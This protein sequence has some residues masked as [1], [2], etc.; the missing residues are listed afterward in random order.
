MRTS[1]APSQ[2]IAAR[3]P[4]RLWLGSVY[5]LVAQNLLQCKLP[6]SP[7]FRA[8][9]HLIQSHGAIW[10]YMHITRTVYIL[11]MSRLHS[12]MEKGNLGSGCWK[13]AKDRT[14]YIT[15]NHFCKMNIAE[16]LFQGDKQ[17]LWQN[18]NL[19]GQ[20]SENREWN[21]FSVMFFSINHVTMCFDLR[22]TGPF[23]NHHRNTCS[24]KTS[25]APSR[26]KDFP[27][28]ETWYYN[29]TEVIKDE[30]RKGFMKL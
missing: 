16:S 9:E 21:M 22:V 25:A 30:D 7:D 15:L 14:V 28:G 3:K 2:A 12:A 19:Q 18:I 5:L 23:S 26:V 27:G 13:T 29:S 1:A 20:H 11:Y 24:S 10:W 4:L 17:Q 6:S 8:M